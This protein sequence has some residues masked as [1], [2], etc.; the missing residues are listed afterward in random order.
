LML[1]RWVRSMANFSSIIG[2]V[3]STIVA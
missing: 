3:L 1:L 2:I